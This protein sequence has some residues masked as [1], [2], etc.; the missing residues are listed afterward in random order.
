MSK[1]TSIPEVAKR[2]AKATFDLAEAEN[3]SEAALKDLTILKKIIIDNAELNRLISSPTFTSTDQLNVMNEIFKKQDISVLVKNLVNVLIRNRRI[4][5]LVSVINAYD[6]IMKSNSGE[7]IA[8][9]ITA[10]ELK[11]DQKQEIVSNLKK[12]TGKEIQ[13]QSKVQPEIIAGI[14]VKIGSQ[15]IDASVS[16]K[17][18]NLKILM[19]GAN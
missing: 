14:K 8:E 17:L 3:L 16:T 7:I 10:A 1:E 4:N 6:L 9:V 5:L 12:M 19:K 18:N 2:Y 15:M 13:I 11:D